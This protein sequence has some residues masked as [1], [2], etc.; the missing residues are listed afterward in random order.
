V[1]IRV[2]IVDDHASF[3]SLA[4][5]LLVDEGFD[6]VGEASDGRGAVR[7]ASELRPDVVLLDVQL[8]DSDG[9]GVAAALAE[10]PHPPAVVLVS[11]RAR[12]DYGHR[13]DRSATQGFIAKAELSGAVL[14]QL[15]GGER[16]AS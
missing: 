2:L 7:A 13:V 10:Q 15:L 9:F 6:V 5:R 1:P 16:T 4:R 11:S 12:A 8:S 14:R 3:R